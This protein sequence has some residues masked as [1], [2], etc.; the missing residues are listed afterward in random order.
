M[1]VS[2]VCQGRKRKG[3]LASLIFE[4]GLF[5]GHDT[6]NAAEDLGS[7]ECRRDVVLVSLDLFHVYPNLER[8]VDF[9]VLHEVSPC[10]ARLLARHRA[11][12]ALFHVLCQVELDSAQSHPLASACPVLLDNFKLD[13][14]L[15][16]HA[17]LVHGKPDGECSLI[18][19]G[20]FMVLYIAALCTTAVFGG[21]RVQKVPFHKRCTGYEGNVVEVD[22]LLLSGHGYRGH[23]GQRALS[24]AGQTLA[25]Q[26]VSPCNMRMYACAS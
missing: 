19:V 3:R 12:L 21:C 20:N 6:R 17:V 4:L 9:A 16:Q 11:H 15:L 8:A 26:F 10:D 5:T 13:V 1:K 25:V 7:L 18:V 22:D 2:R 14:A 24:G 23:D